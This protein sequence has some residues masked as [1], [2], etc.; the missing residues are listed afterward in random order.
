MHT[1]SIPSNERLSIIVYTFY[2]LHSVLDT[3]TVGRNDLG[4]RLAW[5]FV[6][7][8]WPILESR[9]GGQVT[10]SLCFSLTT[11]HFL[12]IVRSCQDV[13]T[14]HFNIYIIYYAN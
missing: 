14:S 4:S 2:V 13:A 10:L 9:Y 5:E 1:H 7:Q 3:F 6:K 8:N 12:A 11:S